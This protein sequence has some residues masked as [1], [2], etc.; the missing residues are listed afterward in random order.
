MVNKMSEN[1]KANL[2]TVLTVIVTIL[3]LVVSGYIIYNSG[4]FDEYRKP[5]NIDNQD[6]INGKIEYG[7]N[8]QIL[9]EDLDEPYKCD[10]LKDAK[11]IYGDIYDG[12]FITNDGK[13]YRLSK[14]KYQDNSQNCLHYADDVRIERIVAGLV[15]DTNN[16]L[17]D[18]ATLIND[19]NDYDYLKLDTP[20]SFGKYVYGE[21]WSNKDVLLDT[22]YK[23]FT[24]PENSDIQH[25]YTL[26]L[27]PDGNIY[28]MHYRR[29]TDINTKETSKYK[30]VDEEL[31]LKLENEKVRIMG[32]EGEN[33]RA[34]I[35]TDKNVY[36][37]EITDSECKKDNS[38]ICKC[39]LVPSKA[40]KTFAPK[41]ISL[42]TSTTFD[43]TL[44]TV[45]TLDQK[46]YIRTIK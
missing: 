38:K 11:Y 36:F 23:I 44:T 34:Y 21:F 45:T 19:G 28:R 41:I 10:E 37:E 32:N 26:V 2:I 8:Y 17:Y 31:V 22:T 15:A 46:I 42:F 30:Y 20:G 9:Y 29:N 33:G 14:T 4:L 16:N 24:D 27:K 1:K 43:P 40:Y 5:N 12:F 3:I 7:D 35:I 6:K 39:T 13:L 18:S 25:M